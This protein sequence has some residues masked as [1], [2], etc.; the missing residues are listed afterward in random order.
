M[1]LTARI[2]GTDIDFKTSS[3]HPDSFGDLKVVA[4]KEIVSL[5]I[6]PEKLTASSGGVHLTPREFHEKVLRRDKS[7]TVVIDCRNGYE[8][9]VGFFEDA[10][11][12][13]T[14]CFSEW[15]EAVDMLVD[16]LQLKDKT[17]F[18]Y[19]TGGIRCE[20]GSAYLRSK[21]VENVFQLSGGIHRYLEQID[22]SESLF[23]GKN[24]VFDERR[25][26]GPPPTDTTNTTVTDAASTAVVGKCLACSAA[27]E[28][29]SESNRCS[30]CR[31]LLLLCHGCTSVTDGSSPTPST[32]L[33]CQRCSQGGLL[34]IGI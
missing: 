12:P 29:Y 25:M 20:R 30:K 4:V 32:E 19:C 7:N 33:V 21:G 3:G 18:M 22:V 14:R 31:T 8:S 23:K 11:K 27:W 15:P 10:I 1:A 28:H 24:F 5:G 9:K 16:E 13:E 34:N 17:V 6:P 2:F 26:M